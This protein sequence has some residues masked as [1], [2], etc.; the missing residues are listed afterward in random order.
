MARHQSRVRSPQPCTKWGAW[1]DVRT[2]TKGPCV[3]LI[4]NTSKYQPSDISTTMGVY[5]WSAKNEQLLSKTITS[6][7]IFQKQFLPDLAIDTIT[8]LVL[9][10]FICCCNGRNLSFDT[11]WRASMMPLPNELPVKVYTLC[12]VKFVNTRQRCFVVLQ[13]CNLF[14]IRV[15]DVRQ[16]VSN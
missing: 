11:T 8:S 7:S 14:Q 3:S 12:V 9:C 5:F 1:S 4:V 10:Q 13:Q 2:Y 6:W 16:A 15:T